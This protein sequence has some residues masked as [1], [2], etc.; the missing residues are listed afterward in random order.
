M[1]KR[2]LDCH[3]VDLPYTEI[4][5]PTE[6]TAVIFDSF[7]YND[8]EKT[9]GVQFIYEIDRRE[10][11]AIPR[12]LIDKMKIYGVSEC[13]FCRRKVQQIELGRRF[14]MVTFSGSVYD[15]SES[16]PL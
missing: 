4:L 8:I 10:V 1:E 15:I 12:D 14:N 6:Q 16:Y 3:L 2:I 11:S 7:G 5:E 9:R 13:R